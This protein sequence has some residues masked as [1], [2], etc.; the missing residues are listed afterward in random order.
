[1]A[2]KEILDSL[3]AIRISKA[4][5]DALE[6]AAAKEG[7]SSGSEWVRLVLRKEAKR[8]LQAA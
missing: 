4:E 3:L 8:V 6:A 1:M 2:A 5:K 7:F